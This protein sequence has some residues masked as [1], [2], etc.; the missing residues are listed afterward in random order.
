MVDEGLSSIGS[1]VGLAGTLAKTDLSNMV[2]IQLPVRDYPPDRNRV[3]PI[4]ELS[5]RIF[6]LLRSDQPLT[7]A[8]L[9]PGVGSTADPNHLPQPAD[10]VPSAPSASTRLKATNPTSSPAPTVTSTAPSPFPTAVLGQTAG[11]YTCAK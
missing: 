8:K 7:P 10:P 3:E 2:M 4:P 5:N 6:T 11:D 1:L 9:N